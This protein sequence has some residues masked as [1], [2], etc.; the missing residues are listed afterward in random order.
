M[1]AKDG[2]DIELA[3]LHD[4]HSHATLYA[5]FEGIP[6][7]GGLDKP[8]ALELISRLPREKLSVVKEWRTE[9]LSLGAAELEEMP[10]AVIVNASLHGFA[11]TP[12]AAGPIASLWPEL[13]ESS[14]DPAWGERHL[15]EL[16][17]FYE[18]VA[19]LDGAKLEA[20]MSRMEEIGL[21]SLEDMTVSSDES[22]DLIAGSPYAQRIRAWASISAYRRLSARSRAAC[23]GIKIFLDGSLGAGTAALDAPFLDGREGLLLYG[24]AEL[25]TLLAEIA[26]YGANLSVHAIGRR[27]IEEAI[28][29][30]EDLR[31][32][33]VEFDA[34]RIEHA[35][36]ISRLQAKRCKNLGVVLSMQ[37]NFNYDSIDYADRLEPRH[38]AENDP[39]R[40]LIDELGFV[41]GRDL[42]FGSDGMPHGPE[43]A[44]TQS[45]FPASESQRMSPE[46]L[47]AGYGKALGVEGQRRRYRIGEAERKVERVARS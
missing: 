45:L 4:H 34:P 11:A 37:P 26:S 18:R 27:A 2:S 16:F 41:P 32:D 47:E 36:F 19:G 23:A 25:E 40:M 44:L 42:I 15:P 22:L 10:P 46:E 9:R 3:L 20:F 35:Q 31:R 17:A 6:D 8:S 39:F 7:I 24:E 30:L 43:H 21:G 13:A 14:G 1:S 12:S 38:R 33:G 29:C 28:Q 5:A